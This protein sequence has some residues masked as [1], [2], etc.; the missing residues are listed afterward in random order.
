M[1]TIPLFRTTT[2]AKK[3]NLR[4]KTPCGKRAKSSGSP[5]RKVPAAPKQ[6]APVRPTG[7]SGSRY[8]NQ[9]AARFLVDLLSGTNSLGPGFGR[10]FR[11]DWQARDQGWL[12]DDLALSCQVGSDLVRSIGL[13]IKSNE[14]VTTHGF[15]KD[16]VDLAWGQWLGAS[17]TRA[18]RKGIDAIALVPAEIPN[19]V[20]SD[21]SALLREIGETTPDRILSRLNAPPEEGSQS[22]AIQRAL[23]Q[24]FACP[25]RYDHTEE[26]TERMQLLHD[27]RVLHFYFDK[28]T[29][30]D[31]VRALGDCQS[32][33]WSGDP[34]EAR[35]LW[36][37]LIAIA[38]EKR[39]AGGSIDAPAL[40]AMLRGRFRLRDHADYR[41]DLPALRR[42]S[43]EAMND[44]GT[45][46]AGVGYVPR[47]GALEIVRKRL[48]SDRSCILVGESGN[49]KSALLK[50]IALGDYPLTAWLTRDALHHATA[51][52]FE[53]ATGLNHPLTDILLNAAERCLVVFDGIEAYSDHALRLATT[54]A[55]RLS[56]PAF[57]HVQV[58]F[59][60]QFEGLP[61]LN[62]LRAAGVAQ[63]MLEP[64]LIDR[65]EEPEVQQALASFPALQW[66]ALRPE[67]GPILTNLK[68][69][70]WFARLGPRSQP[71]GNAP[72]GITAVI[73]DLWGT[74][75]EGV[76]G[77]L[78]RS[79]VLMTLATT[80]ADTLTHGLPRTQ[81]TGSQDTLAGLSR[82]GL[83]RIRHDRVF[84]EHDLLGDWARYKVLV[85]ES[86]TPHSNIEARSASP[87]WQRAVRL[88][89]QQL[90]R[91]PAGRTH[92]RQTV[93][94]TSESSST[95][96]VMR[97]LFVDALFLS[98]D[99]YQLLD[100]NW[101]Q[102]IV[103][104]GRL[105]NRMLERFLIVATLPHPNLIA[106]AGGEKEAEQLEHLLRM[107]QWPYWPAVLAILYK[108]RGDVARVAPHVVARICD[109]WLR[110]TPVEM[111]LRRQVA[112][113]AIEI[114]REIQGRKA[115][116]SY[117]SG[118]KDKIV[119]QVM[120]YAAPFFPDKVAAL[121]LELAR[122]RDP[123]PDIVA[124][125]AQASEKR[126]KEQA[127][128]AAK[129][130]KRPIPPLV[131]MHRRR[132]PPWPDGPRGKIDYE[133]REACLSGQTLTGLVTATPAA[134]LEI[135]LAVSIEEPPDDDFMGRSSRP[136]FGLAFWREGDPPAF[137]R[138][139]FYAFFK[140]ASEQALTFV[141][142][143][144]NFCTHRYT[145]DRDW[146]DLTIDGQTRRWYGDANV[147][148]WH[149]DGLMGHGAQAQSALMALEQWLY[150]E[151]DRGA[152]VNSWIKRI[153][154][155][156]ESLAFAGLLMDVGIDGCLRPPQPPQAQDIRPA[157]PRLRLT[158][159]HEGLRD[160]K[161]DF[162]HARH[163]IEIGYRRAFPEP[164]QQATRI[165]ARVSHA[166]L[167]APV[168]LGSQAP[169]AH[170]QRE[171]ATHN[172]ALPDCD[173]SIAAR[174]SATARSLRNTF[175]R[176]ASLRL[177]FMW[178]HDGGR[179]WRWG[180]IA[181]QKQLFQ[182]CC[183]NASGRQRRAARC[184][185]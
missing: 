129:A 157:N 93:D 15:P 18:F 65:A 131:G 106:L 12:A 7:G 19:A 133:F 107:P 117:Y 83:V 161:Q 28:P 144:T 140:L 116:G 160:V 149:H 81:F 71:V 154:A 47:R 95:A 46:I 64:T 119:Y 159:D 155:E 75:T 173:S 76:D 145:E 102:L 5:T 57:T 20:F 150:G 51:R 3:K 103:D 156:S 167:I 104:N 27:V 121:C 1:P 182:S 72:V 112:E 115:E 185:G 175:R 17:T 50:E 132:L 45:R 70:D 101:D 118:G 141:I 63:A 98:P 105:L 68:V 73:D 10:V 85:S 24:S 40:R 60:L 180:R 14:Q 55:A 163:G 74:W 135:L 130:P 23:V 110:T 67:L 128:R 78:N 151:I 13:S 108:R 42:M 153:V 184:S 168:L 84:F 89:A 80:E 77:G 39:P 6:K 146:L 136:K 21:W 148:R 59:A 9:I 123:S 56:E 126:F 49:G 138:G 29:S 4:A 31:Q 164:P 41:A 87:P 91:T 172:S 52:E 176:L 139:P 69:L 86:G 127:T 125:A 111:P 34:S 178:P 66:L 100:Q 16:F 134:A 181:V 99:A 35:D 152:P 113:L 44:I 53:R 179:A 88:F 97:D 165:A 79:H 62:R 122:R 171:A 37:R 25:L 26:P 158:P 166:L 169:F 8:E 174:Q 33:L 82:S 147:Y 36:E 143:L 170:A 92:W 54:I 183:L 2:M 114:A 177:G 38:D 162:Q 61:K 11:V 48:A 58:A 124:R 142:K 96:G 137:F 109:L 94:V 43:D 22:S 120:L 90:F 30:Q 32:L